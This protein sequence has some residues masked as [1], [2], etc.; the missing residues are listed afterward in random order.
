MSRPGLSFRDWLI[1]IIACMWT[2]AGCASRPIASHTVAEPVTPPAAN[3]LLDAELLEGDVLRPF[4][5]RQPGMRQEAYQLCV[6]DQIRVAVAV[7]DAFRPSFYRLPV[8]SSESYRLAAGDE[9]R[10]SVVRTDPGRL[11]AGDEVRVAVAGRED[12]GY[13]GAILSDGSL[14]L[15]LIGRTTASGITAAELVVQLTKQYKTHLVDPRV[16]VLV[17][18]QAGAREDLGFSGP[19]LPDGSVALPLLGTVAAAGRSPA[20]LAQQLTARYRE[21]P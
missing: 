21:T 19:V 5:Y 18:R 3:R 15:P 2:I 12:L 17:L 1:P 10:V 8:V 11:G 16:D 7:Q 4:F 14:T 13:A 20:E 6:G 9:I